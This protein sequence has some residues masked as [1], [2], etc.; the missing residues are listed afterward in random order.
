MRSKV[1]LVI[2]Y[3]SE[4]IGF[5]PSF[6]EFSNSANEIIAECGGYYERYEYLLNSSKSDI[7]ISGNGIEM[8][9]FMLQEHYNNAIVVF[10]NAYCEKERI[11][12]IRESYKEI[13][14]EG[15]CPKYCI[16]MKSIKLLEGFDN[17]EEVA[18]EKLFSSALFNCCEEQ[19]Q[20][21]N[22]I[23]EVS[24]DA[25]M[26]MQNIYNFLHGLYKEDVKELGV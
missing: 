23:I 22:S 2:D 13:I 14:E 17:V 10:H 19:L 6:S 11:S 21:A 24:N 4:K 3:E 25:L 1:E 16:L 20:Q 18:K 26:K 12:K 15:N 7:E 5:N 9:K 8:V